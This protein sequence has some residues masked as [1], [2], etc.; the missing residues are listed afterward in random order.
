[1]TFDSRDRL[2]LTFDRSFRPWSYGVTHR[3]LVLSTGLPGKNTEFEV[4]FLDVLAMRLRFRFDR[5]LITEA[6]RRPE[7]EEFV[8]L[9]ERHDDKYLRL[10]LSDG[11]HEGFVVCGAIHVREHPPTE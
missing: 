6:G 8:E 9:P 11:R 5:L 7:I 2:P 10:S 3:R 4:E 1:M